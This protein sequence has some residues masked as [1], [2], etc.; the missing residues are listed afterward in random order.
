MRSMLGQY[1]TP[2]RL[3]TFVAAQMRKSDV[4]VDLAVGDGA[5]LRAVGKKL[6]AA[7]LIGFDVDRSMVARSSQ[8]DRITVRHSNGL[9][10]H[11]PKVNSTQSLSA[12]GNPPFVGDSV[13]PRGWIEK[14][15]PDVSIKKVGDRAEIQFLA[16]ALSITRASGGRVVFVMPI[17]FAD[18]DR[19]AQ[20]RASLM[21]QFKVVRCVE[22]AGAPF[23]ETEARTIVLVIDPQSSARY[24]TEILEFDCATGIVAPV[25]KGILEPGVLL[26]PLRSWLHCGAHAAFGIAFRFQRLP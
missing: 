3:A 7:S 1:M 5:L 17:G 12:I 16:R 21:R 20:V 23:D 26:Y 19:Y 11:V 8:I 4:V 10:A 18:G 24:S 25:F 13:D 22:V 14:V 9:T 15:F 6:R 2:Q